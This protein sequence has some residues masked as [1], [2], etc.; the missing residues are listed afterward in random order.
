MSG[1]ESRWTRRRRLN[2]AYAA[3]REDGGS[4]LSSSSSASNDDP[5][6]EPRRRRIA[7]KLKYRICTHSFRTQMPY[8]PAVIDLIGFLA[9]LLT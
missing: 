7:G 4:D 9:S 1:D 2:Q 3:G 5:E 6:P 8:F